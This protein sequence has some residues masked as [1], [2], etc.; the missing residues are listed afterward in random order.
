MKKFLSS[1]FCFLCSG[2]CFNPPVQQEVFLDYSVNQK[3]E[4]SFSISEESLAHLRKKGIQAILSPQPTDLKKLCPNCKLDINNP[5]IGVLLARSDTDAKSYA[6]T[7]DYIYAL[8]KAGANI[9]FIS[10]DNVDSQIQNLD[11]ILLP[12]GSFPS[13]GK[14]YFSYGQKKF[15]KPQKRYYAYEYLIKHAQKNQMPL[16]GICAGMQMMSALLSDEKVKLFDNL[17]EVSD[18]PHKKFDRYKRAHPITIFKNTTFFD[19][20]GKEKL[21][22][23]SRHRVGVAFETTDIPQVTASALS[24]DGIVEAIEFPAFPTALGVQFHP[25]V[26]ANQDDVDMQK[27][28]DWFVKNAH[29]YQQ[30][31]HAQ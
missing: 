10:Y 14:W 7:G 17:E 16:L 23:N 9:R 24:A 19:I 2:C 1:L 22:V 29:N 15:E 3:N 26:F 11:G 21:D 28:F 13:Q 27:I 20:L 4:A 30:Q 25:E 6:I 5:T 18:L 31:R 12:G 8:I